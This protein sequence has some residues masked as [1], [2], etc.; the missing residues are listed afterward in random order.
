MIVKN[1]KLSDNGKLQR[2]RRKKVT[3]GEKMERKAKKKKTL[4]N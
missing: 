4:F 1:W 2:R 3:E